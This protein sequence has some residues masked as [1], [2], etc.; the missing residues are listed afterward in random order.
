MGARGLA[1]GL[2][3]GGLAFASAGTSAVAAPGFLPPENLAGAGGVTGSVQTAMAPN[4][5]AIA[6]WEESLSG[7]QS[8]V[9]VAT[10]SPGGHWSS[11]QQLELGATPK[12]PRFPVSVAIDSAGDAAIAWD[13]QAS[14]SS[15]NAL[16]STRA[17]GQPFGAAQTLTGDADPVVGIDASGKVTM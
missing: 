9:R 14:M 6:G 11:P 1:L 16:V 17:A 13:D 10:R 5:F 3:V 12:S 7:G 4:G 2:V 15:D 8:A